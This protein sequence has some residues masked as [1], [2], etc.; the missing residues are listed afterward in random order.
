MK[1]FEQ[2]YNEF[3]ILEIGPDD[4]RI[5]NVAKVYAKVFAGWPW[6]EVSRGTGCNKFYGLE[7]QPKSP[8]P[9]G[10][11]QLDEAYPLE[12]T[13]EYIQKELSQPK[14]KGVVYAL[15]GSNKVIGFGWGYALNSQ[16]FV[17]AKYNQPE[18]REQI[19][20][21]LGNN[22]VYYYLSEVGIIP[23]FQ[24]RRLGTKITSTLTQTALQYS[25][26]VLMR[27]NFNSP[28]VRIAQKLN[29]DPVFGKTTGFVDFENPE[30]VL[31][32]KT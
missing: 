1:E 30:R 12:E 14:A 25:L 9:C 16:K 21:L 17:E 19:C 26:P 11:G 15:E 4:S 28:M 27:T 3:N 18:I 7:F 23:E 32:I 13:L 10:C 24:N 8:C 22:T 20:T 2:K 6:F 29:M 5:E 31:F